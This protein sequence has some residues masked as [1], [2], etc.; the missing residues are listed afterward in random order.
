MKTTS[1][2]QR[3][4]DP[5]VMDRLAIF[6]YM[7]SNWDWSIAGQH[8]VEVIK[9]VNNNSAGLGKAIPYDFDL[10]GVVNAEYAVPPPS[11]G[12]KDIRERLFLGVCSCL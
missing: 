10:T 4:I 5:Y 11:L 2:T 3:D 1:L 9:P 8:N 12:I 6:N 7:V